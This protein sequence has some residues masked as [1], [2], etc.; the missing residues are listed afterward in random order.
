MVWA[1]LPSIMQELT[2]L[3]WLTICQPA[4]AYPKSLR[5]DI[6]TL[7]RNLQYQAEL[8]QAA[9]DRV[10]VLEAELT[11]IIATLTKIGFLT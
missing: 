8:R 2:S 5:N 1:R 4:F 10:A 11:D 3:R 9:Q 6:A 7:K